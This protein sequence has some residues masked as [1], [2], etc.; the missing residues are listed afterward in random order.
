MPTSPCDLQI[1]LL[2]TLFQYSSLYFFFVLNNLPIAI[3]AKGKPLHFFTI[4]STCGLSDKCE[5]KLFTPNACR[6]N[7]D[8]ALS[9]DKLCSWFR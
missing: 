5:S 3:K 7:K 9:R 8:I 4:P 1:S 2:N 6:A